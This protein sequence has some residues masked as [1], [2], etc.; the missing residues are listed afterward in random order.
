[1]VEQRSQRRTTIRLSGVA[2]RELCGSWLVTMTTG[3]RRPLFGDDSSLVGATLAL[4]VDVAPL[5]GREFH[6]AWITPDSAHLL[7][8]ASGETSWG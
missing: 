7:D 8:A 5:R 2:Y 6:L 1:M 3:D 4:P